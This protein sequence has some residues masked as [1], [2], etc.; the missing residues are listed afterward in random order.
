MTRLTGVFAA[1]GRGATAPVDADALAR[2]WARAV[3]DTS[4][5]PM[6]AREIR[7]AAVLARRDAERALQASE[8]RFRAVFA[9]SAFGIGIADLSGRLIEANA[10]LA[11]MTGYPQDEL[12][13]RA[14]ADFVHPSEAADVAAL[15]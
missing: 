9:G 10:T 11:E 12:R 5:V 4:Y 15:L 3:T 1:P 14:V 7:A 2:T 6:S 13:G 8:A